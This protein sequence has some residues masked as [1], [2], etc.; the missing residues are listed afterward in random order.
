MVRVCTGLKGLE[1]FTLEN[2]LLFVLD[3]L[4][5]QVFTQSSGSSAKK[6]LFMLF[7]RTSQNFA[8]LALAPWA[9]GKKVL[10]MSTCF[11]L[12]AKVRGVSDH[13]RFAVKGEHL[14]IFILKEVVLKGSKYWMVV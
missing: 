13:C 7:K 1:F 3:H 14:F 9:S 6:S 12:L 10:E 5:K 4:A 11:G 8:F 2:A